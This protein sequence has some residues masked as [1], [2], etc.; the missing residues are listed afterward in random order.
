MTI[1]FARVVVAPLKV[2]RD[3]YQTQ[4]LL[5]ELLCKRPVMLPSSLTY[6]SQQ[7][8]VTDLQFVQLLTLWILAGCWISLVDCQKTIQ[9]QVPRIDYCYDTDD[10][11]KD[12]THPLP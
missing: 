9:I 8:S 7:E 2:Q 6:S 1:F 10:D 5:P 4:H 3:L 12:V 11:K